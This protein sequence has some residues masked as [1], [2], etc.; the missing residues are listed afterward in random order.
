MRKRSDARAR[1]TLRLNS[2][3]CARPL[4]EP[5]RASVGFVSTNTIAYATAATRAETRSFWPTQIMLALLMPF[6]RIR[7]SVVMP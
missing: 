7:S 6:N 3:A 2:I 5:Y 1:L 4:N